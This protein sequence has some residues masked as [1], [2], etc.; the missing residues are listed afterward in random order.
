MLCFF[1]KLSVLFIIIIIVLSVIMLSVVAPRTGLL[2][3][4]SPSQNCYAAILQSLKLGTNKLSYRLDDEE[5][6]FL[7]IETRSF[8]DLLVKGDGLIGARDKSGKPKHASVMV[9]SIFFH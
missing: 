7:N 5:K 6:L 2:K 3:F 8:A 4:V 9:S 1:A